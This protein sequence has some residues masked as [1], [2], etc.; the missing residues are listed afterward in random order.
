VR[1]RRSRDEPTPRQAPCVE[2][3]PSRN[4]FS[5]KG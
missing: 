5:Q 1:A 3:A 4:A 2:P